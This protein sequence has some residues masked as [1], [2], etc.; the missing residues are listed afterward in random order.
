MKK[1]SLE[2]MEKTHGGDLCHALMV[3]IFNC[4]SCN[5]SFCLEQFMQ[6]CG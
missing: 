2:Q 1:L 6:N 5:Y 4:S 3:C